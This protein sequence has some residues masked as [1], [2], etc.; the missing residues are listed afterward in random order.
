MT[1]VG[2]PS[3]DTT[4]TGAA[5]PG[6]SG[7]L[8][9]RTVSRVGFGA[10]QLERLRDDRRAGLA[11]LRRAVELGIDHVDTAHFY[12][13]AFVN[14]L[15]REALRPEDGVLVVSK[16]GADP[17]PGGRIPC[18]PRSGPRSSGRASRTTSNPWVWTRSLW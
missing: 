16:V 13:N 12:G 5:R 4:A 3:S 1:T 6:G 18:A 14:G 9:G 15:L 7:R 17:D 8:A 2:T 10:M 11:L